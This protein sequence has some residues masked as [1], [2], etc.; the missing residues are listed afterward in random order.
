MI[1]IDIDPVA[2][3]IGPFAVRWY[4]IAIGVGVLVVIIWVLWHIRRGAT[5]PYDTLF[6]AALVA[7][8]SGIIVSRLLHVIDAWEVYSQDPGRII[9]GEGLTIYGAVLGATLGIWVYSRFSKFNFGYFVDIVAPAI[10]LGQAIGRVGCILNGC[11][12][13]PETTLPWGIL[14]T[15]PDSACTIGMAVHPTQ[16]YEIIYDLMVFGVLVLLRGRLRPDGSLFMVY[17]GLYGVWRVAIGFLRAG[18]PFLFG[19]HQAQVIGLVVLAI[20]VPLLIYRTRWVKK[21]G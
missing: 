2:F 16:F 8:P 20:V 17:M 5:I 21:G 6:T 14:Y 7:I 9:G 19:L 10:I 15:H 11:C 3:V 18:T 13:G 1:T 4:G 12:Y